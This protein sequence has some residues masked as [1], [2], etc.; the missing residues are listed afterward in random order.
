MVR[1]GIFSSLASSFLADL[2]QAY[3]TENPFVHLGFSE[4]GPEEHVA[5]VQH[6]LMDVAFLT[7]EPVAYGCE[8]TGLR[9]GSSSFSR[10]IMAWPCVRK[11]AGTI[12]VTS[13]SS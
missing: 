12:F 3:Q 2:L 11:L 4:G 13:L 8:A 10:N 7:G 6:H 5:A 9:S 1:I